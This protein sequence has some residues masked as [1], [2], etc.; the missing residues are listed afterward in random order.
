MAKAKGE[1]EVEQLLVV[2][3]AHCNPGDMDILSR[4]ASHQAELAKKAHD[5]RDS[6]VFEGNPVEVHARGFGFLIR[7]DMDL[8]DDE[9]YQLIW[10][11][12]KTAGFSMEFL[13]LMQFAKDKDFRWVL[14]D[15]DADKITGLPEGQWE[16]H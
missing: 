11:A 16:E 3:T 5:T 8:D 12:M 7:H 10:E 15:A 2:S 1:L 9:G 13:V 4:L 14:L 6:F